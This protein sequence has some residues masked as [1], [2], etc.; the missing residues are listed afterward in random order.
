MKRLSLVAVALLASACSAIPNAG[1]VVQGPRVDVLR[2]DGYVRVIARPPIA[3]MTPDALVRGFLAASASVA[4][5]DETARLYLTADASRAWNPQKLTVVYDAAALTVVVDRG[6]SVRITAP[7]IGSIDARRRYTTADAGSTMSDDLKLE[8]VD[9]EWRIASAP[10]ALYLGE[11]DVARSFRA[12]PVFFYNSD[13]SR[14]VPEYV[15]LPIGG[16]SLATQLMK[17][18]LGGPNTVYGNAIRSAIPNGTQLAFRLVSVEGVTASVSLAPSVL[19]TTPKQRDDMV[20]QIVWTL[21]SL[22]DVAI[23]RVLVD[24]Q[25]FVVPSGRATHM[26]ADYPELD[27]AYAAAQPGLVYVRGQ[28]VLDYAGNERVLVS[29]GDPMSAAAL[30]RDRTLEAVILKARKLLYISTDGRA[31]QPVAAG[32]DLAKPQFTAD[33]RLWFVDREADGGL[34]TWD[35]NSGVL[36]VQTGLPPGARI[37]DYAIAPDQ[38]RIALIVNDGAATTLRLGVIDTAADGRRVLALMRVEQRLTAITSVTW[39]AMNQLVVLGSAGAVALQPI[40]V[41]LPT[42]AV[43][44]LGGPAN[45]VSLSAAVGQPIVVGDQAGQLWEYDGGRWTASVLGNAPNYI[46]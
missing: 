46:I 2:N 36:Q 4:D 15:L 24:G 20:G 31:L 9:G 13:F 41:T 21:S 19:E 44:V 28:R 35:A 16:G 39:S 45:A 6:D 26:L 5:G 38:T 8:K 18:M 34:R 23:V 17:A 22:T 37:L 43:S 3:K 14:L 42:G 29:S 7:K 40:Q 32:R 1:P 10:Q 30:S 33:N 25:P 11:G 12:Y 27:P